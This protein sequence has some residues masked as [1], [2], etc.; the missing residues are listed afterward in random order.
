MRLCGRGL[1]GVGVVMR[2]WV[3]HGVSDDWMVDVVWEWLCPCGRGLK[4]GA[5]FSPPLSCWWAGL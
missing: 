1:D 5:F 2:W 4:G 3:G